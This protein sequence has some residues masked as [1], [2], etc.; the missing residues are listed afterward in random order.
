MKKLFVVL[1]RNSDYVVQ[2][3]ESLVQYH[4]DDDVII[5]DSDSEDL[6]YVQKLQHNVNSIDLIHN[7]H[8]MDGAIWHVYNN[9]KEYTNYAFLQDS[10][11]LKTDIDFAFSKDI[12]SIQ[13]FRDSYDEGRDGIMAKMLK[14]HTGLNMPMIMTGILGPMMICTRDFLKEAESIGMNNVLPTSKV[15]QNSMERV[16]GYVIEHLGRDIVSN[17]IEGVHRGQGFSDYKHVIKKYVER[18]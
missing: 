6:S 15:C 18:A 3:V 2:C 13:Y 8:Y 5:V 7:K 4:P 1:T 17:S 14:T 12:F 11:E 16:W 9:Y 10:T